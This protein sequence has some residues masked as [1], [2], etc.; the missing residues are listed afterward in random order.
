[1]TEEAAIEVTTTM[2]SAQSPCKRGLNQLLNQKPC[3]LELSDAEA[4][5]V[6]QAVEPIVKKCKRKKVIR[7]KSINLFRDQPLNVKL[8]NGI[9]LSLHF[10][11]PEN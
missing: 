3:G 6:I 11:S 1:M 8:E 7:P 5:A 9:T 2:E 10:A 4:Q